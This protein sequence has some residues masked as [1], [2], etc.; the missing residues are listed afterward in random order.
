MLFIMG[1]PIKAMILAFVSVMFLMMAIGSH[2]DEIELEWDNDEDK[3]KEW[4]HLEEILDTPSLQ[5]T[6]ALKKRLDLEA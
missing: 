1:N 3:E 5:W 6:G 2:L 4:R